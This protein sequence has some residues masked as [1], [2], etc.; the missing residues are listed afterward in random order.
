MITGGVVITY[1]NAIASGE[2]LETTT[3]M[4]FIDLIA[5]NITLTLVNRSFYYSLLTTL[6]YRNNLIIF[7]VSATIVILL[8]IF[9]IEP[10][11][12]FFRFKTPHLNEIGFSLLAG[13]S[14]VIWFEG[15]KIFRRMRNA[16]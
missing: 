14:S 9:L 4:V 1:F 7:V 12:T 5:A 10:L 13:F 2:N 8:C 16:S 6:R 15:Y 11:R 3:A